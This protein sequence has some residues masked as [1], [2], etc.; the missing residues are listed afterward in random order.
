MGEGIIVHEVLLVF[1]RDVLHLPAGQDAFVDVLSPPQLVVLALKGAY[2]LFPQPF[3]FLLTLTYGIVELRDGGSLLLQLA[4][5]SIVELSAPV[6]D[7][8]CGYADGED[9]DEPWQMR[10]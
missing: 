6:V 1:H 8:E 5:L 4:F 7:A 10:Y 3:F 2:G 9:C